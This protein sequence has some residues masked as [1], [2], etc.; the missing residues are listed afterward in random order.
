MIAKIRGTLADKSPGEV[1][2]DVGGVG[3]H[4]FVSLGVFYRLPE[5]GE[6]VSL[7]IHTYVREDALHLFGFLDHGEKQVF[8]LLNSEMQMPKQATPFYLY[9]QLT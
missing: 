3:Y 9:Q 8:L 2:V 5:V 7:Y 1:I 4:V 6:P